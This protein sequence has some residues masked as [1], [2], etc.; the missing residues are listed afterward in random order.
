MS[1][2]KTKKTGSRKVIFKRGKDLP[3]LVVSLSNTRSNKTGSWMSTRPV[4]DRE[5]CT[6]CMLCWK[7]CPESCIIPADNPTITLSYCKGCGICAE[8]CPVKAITMEREKR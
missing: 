3:Y 5:K 2:E 4:V 8:V 6:G 1:P 7:F